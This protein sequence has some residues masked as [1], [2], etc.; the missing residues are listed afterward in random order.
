MHA[1]GVGKATFWA[2]GCFFLLCVHGQAPCRDECHQLCFAWL[3]VFGVVL[4]EFL[5]HCEVVPMLCSCPVSGVGC[6]VVVAFVNL[7][8]DF[9]F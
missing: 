4:D 1:A 5:G 2:F 7:F 8:C 9:C 3:V 6:V